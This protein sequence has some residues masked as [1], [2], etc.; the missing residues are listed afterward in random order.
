[1]K[2]A[3]EKPAAEKAAAGRADEARPS[4]RPLPPDVDVSDDGGV[5]ELPKA[6]RAGRQSAEDKARKELERLKRE[7]GKS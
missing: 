2:A 1:M 5:P 6:A 4:K 7:L 3:A